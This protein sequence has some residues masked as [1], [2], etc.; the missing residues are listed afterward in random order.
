VFSSAADAEKLRREEET[1][2][3]AR[4]RYEAAKERHSRAEVSD[5]DLA[6]AN[7]DLMMAEAR[8]DGLKIAMAHYQFLEWDYRELANKRSGADALWKAEEELNK[9]QHA[10]ERAKAGTNVVQKALADLKHAERAWGSGQRRRD[11][12]IER[13][14]VVTNFMSPEVLKKLENDYFYADLN[15]KRLKQKESANP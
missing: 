5:R 4:E 10:I 11:L 9:A 6:V 2:Q 3:F 7:R 8:G 12:R 14:G 1:I 13:D 15:Y